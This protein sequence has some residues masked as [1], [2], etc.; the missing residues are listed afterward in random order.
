LYALVNVGLYCES[1]PVLRHEARVF[2][3][4]YFSFNFSSLLSK[5]VLD[6]QRLADVAGEYAGSPRR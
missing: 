2:Q 5:L 3:R 4:A 1:A 6:I